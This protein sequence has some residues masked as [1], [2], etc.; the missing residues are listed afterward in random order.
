MSEV[1]F[2]QVND[3][4]REISSEIQQVDQTGRDRTETLLG[5]LDDLAAHVLACQAVVATMAKKY[6][7]AMGDVD[8]WL[9]A[10]MDQEG[11]G[12]DKAEAAAR[13]IVTGE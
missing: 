5:A 7:V 8:A 4:L 1:L 11:E 10:N 6:P 13:H 12:A 3:K 9:K 2:S